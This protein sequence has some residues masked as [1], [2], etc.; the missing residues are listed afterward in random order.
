MINREDWETACRDLIV[1]GRKRLG[2]PPTFEEAE[3]LS[4]GKLPEA[5]AERIRELLSCYPDLLRVLVVP[6]PEDTAGILT[7]EEL[8]ADLSKIR[9][10]IRRAA[11]PQ[12]GLPRRRPGLRLFAIAA[13]LVI[14]VA[15]GSI[16]VWRM[17][18]PRTL[19]TQ[20]LYPDGSRAVSGRS[21]VPSEAPKQLFTNADYVLQPL[22]DSRRPY[23]EYRIELL[24]LPSPLSVTGGASP[25]R[26]VW[27]QKVIPHPDG[28]F[29]VRLSTDDLAPGLY[30]LVLY[31]VNETPES[32]AEYTVR[33]SPR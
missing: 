29:P 27:L 31:G 18:G 26:R 23:R 25:P 5:E 1:G 21:G 24:E 30:R 9:S 2:P 14:A 4:E 12:P 28:T 19:T 17:T 10:R 15:A 22:F 20:E 3:A 13:G 7:D 11:V 6:F 8:A 32:L 33:L 16:A